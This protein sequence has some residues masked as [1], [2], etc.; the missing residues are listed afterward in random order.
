VLVFRGYFNSRSNP[1]QR[2]GNEDY[3]AFQLRLNPLSM[4]R[5]LRSQQLIKQS[6]SSSEHSAVSSSLGSPEG[7]FHLQEI[8]Q[9]LSRA[10]IAGSAGADP[11]F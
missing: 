7:S 9:E 11:A 8:V 10:D 1:E 6:L 3:A 2:K 4:E 5:N